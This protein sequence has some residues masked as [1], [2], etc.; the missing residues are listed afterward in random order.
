MPTE[1]TFADLARAMTP[2]KPLAEFE[3]EQEAILQAIATRWQPIADEIIRLELEQHILSIRLKALYTRL[4]ARYKQAPVGAYSVSVPCSS[5]S[6]GSS[7]GR[8]VRTV[9][10]DGNMVVRSVACPKCGGMDEPY[11][12][13]RLGITQAVQSFRM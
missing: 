13:S 3:Q 1:P 4:P 8:P 11:W 5:C 2:P 6:S 7:A 9:D 12:K 10:L